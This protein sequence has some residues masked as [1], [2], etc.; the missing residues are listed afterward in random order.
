MVLL[1]FRTLEN[2]ADISP[3]RNPLELLLAP[4]PLFSQSCYDHSIAI[5]RY[6]AVERRYQP[7]DSM[8]RFAVAFSQDVEAVNQTTDKRYLLDGKSCIFLKA[9]SSTFAAH[10]HDEQVWFL[11]DLFNALGSILVSS[12][13]HS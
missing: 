11:Q 12:S 5:L 7:R 13:S 2:I 6:V 9:V 1:K 4:Q 10:S 8:S 3:F